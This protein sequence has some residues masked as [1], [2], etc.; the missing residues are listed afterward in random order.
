MTTVFYWILG[1]VAFC[2]IAVLCAVD[3][4]CVEDKDKQDNESGEI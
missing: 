4:F 2:V 1:I 3:I